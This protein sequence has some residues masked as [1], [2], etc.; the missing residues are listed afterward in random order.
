MRLK[1]KYF[2]KLAETAGLHEEDKDLESVQ[3]L[4]EL[5]TLIFEEYQFDESETIQV[6]VNQQLDE[7]K[8]LKEGDEI[9]FLPP[10][11]GG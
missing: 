4:A 11:A 1:L 2:G 10:F 8:T 7:N 5:K 9:A 6:A 3:T